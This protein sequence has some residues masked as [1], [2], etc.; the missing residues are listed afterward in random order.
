MRIF[1][2]TFLFFLQALIAVSPAVCSRK[3]NFLHCL[4]VPAALCS[5]DIPVH[6]SPPPAAS[7]T[8]DPD[9]ALASFT[10]DFV[11]ADKAVPLRFVSYAISGAAAVY[12]HSVGLNAEEETTDALGRSI[13][14]KSR[15]LLSP[16][17]WTKVLRAANLQLSVVLAQLKTSK[18]LLIV[19]LSAD[20]EV[21]SYAFS[22]E[23]R[24]DTFLSVLAWSALKEV[25]EELRFFLSRVEAVVVVDAPPAVAES[26]AMLT[27]MMYHAA[28]FSECRGETEQVVRDAKLL[29]SFSASC[30]PLGFPSE[31]DEDKAECERL[32]KAAAERV[33]VY[34]QL[35]DGTQAPRLHVSPVGDAYYLKRFISPPDMPSHY[36]P[37]SVRTL[38]ASKE[39]QNVNRFLSKCLQF[40]FA[41]QRLRYARPSIQSQPERP[42]LDAALKALKSRLIEDL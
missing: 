2:A 14:T 41:T 37:H 26:H 30:A 17:E 39:Q 40:A 6:G 19:N 42:V 12:I 21:L 27:S 8:E 16:D 5:L 18:A 32:A 15:R 10:S 24:V 7:L 22:P 35:L 1:F 3:D 31:M 38:E 34:T 25:A 36:L 13:T 9:S 29:S 20:S 33:E 23:K 11:F 4:L 28:S